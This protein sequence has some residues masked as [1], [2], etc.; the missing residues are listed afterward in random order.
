MFYPQ[1]IRFGGKMLFECKLIRKCI[2]FALN[3]RC[4]LIRL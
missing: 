2:Y 1:T 3:I 4:F